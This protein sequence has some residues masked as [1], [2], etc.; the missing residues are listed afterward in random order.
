MVRLC[1]ILEQKKGTIPLTTFTL[2]ASMTYDFQDLTDLI[3]SLQRR[4]G[5]EDC[6]NRDIDH[7]EDVDCTWRVLCLEREV[8]R[9]RAPDCTV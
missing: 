1:P 9:G 2:G 5:K 4:E 6:F 8:D 3:R 7:C